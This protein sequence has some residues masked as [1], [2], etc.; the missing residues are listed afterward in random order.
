MS[1]IT[2]GGNPVNTVGTL[3]A[4]GTT[5]PDFK[6]V[7][8][9]LSTLTYSDLKG[10]NVIFNIFPSLDTSTCAS[11]VRQFNQKAASLENTVVLCVSKDLPFAHNRFCVA[12]GISN[13]ITGSSF[14]DNSFGESFGV[15]MA[16][17][18]LEGLLSRAVVIADEMGVVQYTEQVPEIAS[19]PDYEAALNALQIL[20]HQN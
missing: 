10:K 2:L 4:I 19:E 17:G 5:V 16:D 14:R 1:K 18:K 12:E 3:P 15:T 9:D 11:S 7:K 6:I 13:V 20:M 8:S